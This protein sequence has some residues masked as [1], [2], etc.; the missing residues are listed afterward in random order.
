VK[1][2]G[3]GAMMRINVRWRPSL[4]KTITLDEARRLL[5]SRD[6]EAFVDA[7]ETWTCPVF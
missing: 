3:L 5:A 4:P 7:V 6:Y 1:S 2:F